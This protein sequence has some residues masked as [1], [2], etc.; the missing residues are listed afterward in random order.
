MSANA[1]TAAGMC[2][3]KILMNVA[4]GKEAK[5]GETFSY[6]VDYL[7]KNNHVPKN[8]AKWVEK[9]KDKGNDANHKI[10]IL[11]EDDAKELIERVEMLLKMMYSYSSES[12]DDL[13]ETTAAPETS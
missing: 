3:R 9:I 6:Y 11:K 13:E 7:I 12:D 4:V 5:Q 10:E 8:L 2:C 1:P